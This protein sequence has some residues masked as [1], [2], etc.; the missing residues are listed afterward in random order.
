MLISELYKY[1]Y[2][3]KIMVILFRMLYHLTQ[4]LKTSPN[5]V[6]SLD[7][8]VISNKNN[9]HKCKYAPDL[10]ICIWIWFSV[11]GGSSYHLK[12]SG[13]IQSFFCFFFYLEDPG[14]NHRKHMGTQEG[15]L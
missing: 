4:N 14:L 5:I 7:V 9:N 13:Y 1:Y 12:F 8:N 6:S 2:F 15:I 10:V 3:H 11:Y